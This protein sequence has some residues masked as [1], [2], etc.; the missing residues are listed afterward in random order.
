M[1]VF[2]ACSNKDSIPMEYRNLASEVA[3]TLAKRGHKLI[4][5]G[6]DTGMVQKCYMAFKYEGA[7]TKAIVDIKNTDILNSLEVDAYDVVTNVMQSYEKIFKSSH[8]IIVMPGGIDTF[9]EFFSFIS[10]LKIRKSNVKVIL[11]NYKHFFNPLIEF[12]KK[13]YETN[14]IDKKELK[15]FDIVTDVKSL[16]MYLNY[17]EKEIGGDLE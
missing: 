10:E 8:A 1:R 5:E 6:Y 4:F 9:A 2:M 13:C 15:L 14:F 12:M 11:F 17:V 7:K 16:D 3:D